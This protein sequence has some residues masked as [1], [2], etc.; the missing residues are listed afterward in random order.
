MFRH[1]A[2][3][4]THT[5]VVGLDFLLPRRHATVKNVAK[6]FGKHPM[7]AARSIQREIS[8]NVRISPTSPVPST[9]K[10]VDETCV[11]DVTTERPMDSVEGSNA[12]KGLA[13]GADQVALFDQVTSQ[14]RPVLSAGDIRLAGQLWS[15]LERNS[16]LPFLGSNHLDIIS[17]A[18]SRCIEIASAFE[19]SDSRILDEIALFAAANGSSHGLEARMALLI[20]KGDPDAAVSLFSR[21]YQRALEKSI[22]LV[23]RPDEIVTSEGPTSVPPANLRVIPE[24]IIQPSIFSLATV[25]CAMNDSFSEL[26]NAALRSG[27]PLSTYSLTACWDALGLDQPLRS[28]AYAYVRRLVTARL[29][30]SRSGL[31]R[32]VSNLHNDKNQDALQR[33]YGRVVEALSGPQPWLTVDASAVSEQTPVLLPEFTWAIILR[34]FMHCN[35]LDFAEKVWDDM[36]RFGVR[37]TMDTWTSL[38]DGYAALRLPDRLLAVWNMLHETGVQPSVMAYR[39]VIYG[40]FRSERPDDAMERFQELQQLLE[41]NAFV[42]NA[43]PDSAILV[44]YNTV[45]HWLLATSRETDA[46]GVFQRME[47]DGPK[48]DVISY[49]TFLKYYRDTSQPGALGGLIRKMEEANVAADVVTYSIILSTLLPVTKSAVTIVSDLMKKNGLEMNV[50]LYT[51]IIEDLIKENTDTGLRGAL[52]MLRVMESEP[53]DGCRPNEITYTAILRSLHR[54]RNWQDPRVAEDYVRMIEH[55][56]QKQGF[57]NN[58]VTYNILIKACLETRG[59]DGIKNALRYYREMARRMPIKH[60]TWYILLK[61]LSEAEEWEVAD[62]VIEDIID[63]GHT[64]SGSLNSLIQVVRTRQRRDSRRTAQVE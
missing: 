2:H 49:N 63:S 10:S 41:R 19:P 39:A 3:R 52:D 55:K 8:S 25:A 53:T 13:L 26:L 1:A 6:S 46:Q 45:L 61:G 35:R 9:S 5:P 48:P 17:T 42:H 59:S 50:A 38:L 12:R 27:G 51:T 29:L 15:T 43:S 34:A 64:P 23:V 62:A 14:L 11:P 16:L 30:S 7:S 31:Q 20:R 24:H 40:L 54:R 44:T 4:L 57:M 58:K 56:M 37:P 47:E 60:D 28:K 33:L 22:S 36:T 21:L 18:I 32:H